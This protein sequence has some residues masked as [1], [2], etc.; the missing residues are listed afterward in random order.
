MS[1]RRRVGVH[2]GGGLGRGRGAITGLGQGVVGVQSE[3]SASEPVLL[4]EK[5]DAQRFLDLDEGGVGDDE[6]RTLV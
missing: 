5:S 1:V 3:E 4:G 6:F 2:A